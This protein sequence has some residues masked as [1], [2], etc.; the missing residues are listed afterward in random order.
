MS[1]ELTVLRDEFPEYRI[2]RE[3]TP[4]RSRYVA[5]SRYQGAKPAHRRYR[6]GH[7]AAGCPRTG[8]APDNH[9]AGQLLPHRAEY[10]THVRLLAPGEGPL[11]RRPGR[12]RRDHRAVPRGCRDRPG[13]PRVPGPRGAVR[14]PAGHQAVPRPWFRPAHQPQRARDCPVG[15]TPAPG[16]SMSITIRSCWPTP[17]RCWPPTRT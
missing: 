5:R 7:R 10:R 3:E 2:W 12:R 6:P 1:D 17:G 15:Q 11:R 9:P 13:Q 16:S 8:R 14:S 4:G